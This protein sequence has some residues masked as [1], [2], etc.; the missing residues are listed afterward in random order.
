MSIGPEAGNVLVHPDVVC[1]HVQLGVSEFDP[2]T[3]GLS[4]PSTEIVGAHADIA[5]AIRWVIPIRIDEVQRPRDRRR[6]SLQNP[7]QSVGDGADAG[8]ADIRKVQ[9]SRW[10][11]LFRSAEI[12]CRPSPSA[13]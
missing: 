2:V 1:L 3:G 7:E 9:R 4:L 6:P 8:D 10:R 12:P 5:L 11:A 13:L